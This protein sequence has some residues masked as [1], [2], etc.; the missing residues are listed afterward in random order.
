MPRANVIHT[1]FSSGEVS[2]G[3]LG[4][5][6]TAKYANG[7]KRLKNF[8]VKIQGGL[9][10]RSG[11]K[12]INEVRD[13]SKRSIL[14]GFQ[15]SVV[16]T[17]VLEF[18]EGYIRIYKDYGIVEDPPATPVEVVVPYTEADLDR[19]YFSQSADVL[20]ISHPDYQTRKLSRTS[21]VAWSISL[22]DPV[23]GPYTENTDSDTYLKITSLVDTAVA[24]SNNSIWVVGDVGKYVQ[25]REKGIWKL[26]LITAYTSGTQVTIAPQ[27][28]WPQKEPILHIAFSTYI[29]SPDYSLVFSP[30]DVGKS[31]K[32]T[33][34]TWAKASSYVDDQNLSYAA[35]VLTMASGT[36]PTDIVTVSG[37]VI[38]C[39]ITS[40]TAKFAST[41]VGRKIRMQFGTKWCWGEITVYNSTTSVDVTLYEKPPFDR[42]NQG[43]I[44]D[45][46]ITYE[47]KLGAWSDT[48]GWPSVSVIHEQRLWFGRTSSEPQTIWSSESLDYESMAPT[49]FDSIVIDANAI[50]YTIGSSGQVNE[51]V[52][53]QTGPVLLIGTT[54]GEW[55]IKASS[56]NEPLSPSNIQITGQTSFGSKYTTRPFRVGAAVLFLQNSGTRVREMTYNFEIDAF[57]A[58]DLNVVSDHILYKNGRGLYSAYQQERNSTLWVATSDGKL[59]GMSYERDQEVVAWHPHELGGNGFVESMCVIHDANNDEDVLYLSVRRTINGS[60]VRY[61]EYLK[62]EFQPVDSDDKDEMFFVDCGLSYSGAATAAISGLDHLEG[63]SVVGVADG[64]VIPAITVTSGAVTLPYEAEVVHL[65]LPYISLVEMLPVEGGSEFGTSQGMTKRIDTMVVRLLDSLVMK[66]GKDEDNLDELSFRATEDVMDDSPPLFTGDKELE[67]PIGYDSQSTYVIAQEQPYPLNILAVITSLKTNR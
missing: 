17:Y 34:G 52:W 61:I 14:V 54:G 25:Y 16:Q 22:Y 18:A 65:G 27:E 59:V 42:Y 58:K 47:W 46:G 9:F 39:T 43:T 50:T 24:T 40:S 41:D 8:L 12:Y 66:H 45:N 53:M 35:G 29:S 1:N 36:Y 56:I 30:E 3:M 11:T 20:Y 62:P 5:V 26:G 64:A 7:A 33:A 37:R 57:V 51:I 15:F 28:V 31:F 38:T 60:T 4:R 6:D 44:M 2:P 32:S 10:R 67:T 13:S 19:L 49:G 23:D 21:H 55:Q 63:E 48:T